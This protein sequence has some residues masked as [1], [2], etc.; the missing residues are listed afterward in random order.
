[1]PRMLDRIERTARTHPTA[2]ALEAGGVSLTYDE[3]W[4]RARA[5][6]DGLAAADVLP[7]DHAALIVERGVQTYICYLACLIAG[8]TIVPVNAAHP[9]PRLTA[10]LDALPIDAVLLPGAGLGDDVREKLRQLGRSLVVIAAD[11]VQV[12]DHWQRQAPRNPEAR[13]VGRPM[14]VL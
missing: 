7:G 6:V 14:Y 1:M 13:S 11:R 3:L 2:A 4:A 5:V 10:Q 9:I 12:L 8:I